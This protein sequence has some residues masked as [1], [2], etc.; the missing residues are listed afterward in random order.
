MSPLRRRPLGNGA[1]VLADAA[2][3]LQGG[4]PLHDAV[5][6][7]G[8]AGTLRSARLVL[9]HAPRLV[10]LHDAGVGKDRAGVAGLDRLADVHVAA[11]AVRHDSAR[12]DDADDVLDHGVIAHLN[13]AARTLGLEEGPLRDQLDRILRNEEGLGRTPPGRVVG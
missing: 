10:V 7:C 11:V 2:D 9:R 12:L 1:V 13:D 6:V 3:D 5:L 8:S 4:G